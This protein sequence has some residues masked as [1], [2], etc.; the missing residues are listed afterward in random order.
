MRP[1][2]RY[3]NM[4]KTRLTGRTVVPALAILLLLPLAGSA[5]AESGLYKIDA[6][7]FENDEL[8][9]SPMMIVEQDKPG[10]VGGGDTAFE[11]MVDDEGERD[12]PPVI[13]RT[14]EGRRPHNVG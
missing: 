4:F 8:T 13:R 11:M 3:S 12:G 9:A 6:E 2:S 10:R 1:E 5:L 7:L 14:A